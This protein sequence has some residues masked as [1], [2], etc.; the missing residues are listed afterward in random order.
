MNNENCESIQCEK[1][2]ISCVEIT[3]KIEPKTLKFNGSIKNKIFTIL[4]KYSPFHGYK[5]RKMVEPFSIPCE[6]FHCYRH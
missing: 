5:Y 2:M 6:G 1:P 3:R 4:K